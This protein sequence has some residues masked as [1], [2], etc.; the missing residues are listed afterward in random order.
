MTALFSF[1]LG[2]LLSV[3]LATVGALEKRMAGHFIENDF[4]SPLPYTYLSEADLP[5]DFTWGNVNGTSYL[6]RIL[7]QHIVRVNLAEKILFWCL[8]STDS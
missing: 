1:F 7:N 8:N 6:T 3:L 2:I 4:A 5:L